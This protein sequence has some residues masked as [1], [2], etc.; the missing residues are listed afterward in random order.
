MDPFTHL[1]VNSTGELT[2][3]QHLKIK[4]ALLALATNSDFED[5][6][7]YINSEYIGGR[8]NDRG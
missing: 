2:A 5:V 6:S 8:P 4:N 1:D 3:K 7:F